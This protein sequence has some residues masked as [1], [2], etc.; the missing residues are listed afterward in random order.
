[1][2]CYNKLTGHLNRRYCT[3]FGNYFEIKSKPLF[4]IYDVMMAAEARGTFRPPPV[5]LSLLP[6]EILVPK[7][8]K[9]YPSTHS[10]WY[11][12]IHHG[13]LKPNNHKAYGE[14]NE[15]SH[16]P[17]HGPAQKRSTVSS[18]IRGDRIQ[19]LCLFVC[20]ILF[21][22]FST[23]KSNIQTRYMYITNK[24]QNTYTIIS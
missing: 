4:T 18:A 3:K 12:K 7:L 8:A 2:K 22:H 9:S 24:S 13:F 10:F 23:Y 21:M 15:S 19:T 17:L 14:R 16:C 11:T 5:K 20:L 1:M 6:S